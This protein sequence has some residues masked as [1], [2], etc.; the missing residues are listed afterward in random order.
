VRA[1]WAARV[2]RGRQHRRLNW[3]PGERG[4]FSVFSSETQT[5][6]PGS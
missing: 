1:A 6:K 2:E 5:Q 4:I 3:A